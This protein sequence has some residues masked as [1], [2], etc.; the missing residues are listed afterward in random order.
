MTRAVAQYKQTVLSAFQN[1]A[2]TL[3][4][5]DEDANTLNQTRRAMNAAHD[6]SS[7]TA[8]RYKLGSTPFYATLTAGAA[9]SERA[10][11]VRSRACGSPGR[12]RDS[13]RFDGQSA[14]RL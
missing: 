5:L 10:R 11:P 8:S 4:S 2:D 3:V 7:D 6:A 9:V 1:V 13:V 14:G 12:Y